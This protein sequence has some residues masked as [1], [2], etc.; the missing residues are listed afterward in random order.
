MSHTK[1]S[2]GDDSGNVRVS[3]SC[4][5]DSRE[6]HKTSKSNCDSED[7]RKN[8]MFRTWQW[9]GGQVVGMPG[10]GSLR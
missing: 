8:K 5:V 9:N 4:T 10:T 7:V 1:V 2:G 6:I 3:G